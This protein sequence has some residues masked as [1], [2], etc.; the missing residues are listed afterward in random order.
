[1]RSIG[2]MEPGTAINPLER[3][4]PRSGLPQIALAVCL[5]VVLGVAAWMLLARAEAEVPADDWVTFDSPDG[6]FSLMFPA[7]PETSQT[8]EPDTVYLVTA[9][10]RTRVYA[11]A[12]YDYPQQQVD[13]YGADKLLDDRMATGTESIS[14]VITNHEQFVWKDHPGREFWLDVPGGKAHYRIFLVGRRLYQL[15]IIHMASFEPNHDGFFS[16]FT[17]K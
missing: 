7:E 17:L 11:L 10:M 1:M 13:D 9:D 8:E 16:S 4:K 15:A 5:L 3:R 6:E 2:R 14:G 12:Y